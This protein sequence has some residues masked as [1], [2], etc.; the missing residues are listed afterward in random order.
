M[1]MSHRLMFTVGTV[2]G[3]PY[4]SAPGIQW[5]SEIGMINSPIL[6]IWRLDSKVP[7]LSFGFYWFVF[8]F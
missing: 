3:A 2:E 5:F 4:Q 8:R 6:G 1:V 7:C